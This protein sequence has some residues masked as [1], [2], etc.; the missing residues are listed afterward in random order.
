MITVVSLAIVLAVKM[1]LSGMSID[2]LVSALDQATR[3]QSI[4]PRLDYLLTQFRVIT[5]YIRLIFLPV[6]QRLD[7]DYALSH[8]LFEWQVFASFFVIV[9]LL[10]GAFWLVMVSKSGNPLLRMTAFGII[11]FFLTLSI[12]SSVFPII[13]LIFE[14]RLY[15][16]LFGA[17]TAVSSAVSYATWGRGEPIRR[18]VCIGV[19]LVA[20]TLAVVAYKRNEVWRSEVS[21]W[22]DATEKSPGSARA[23][24]NLAG[25][26]IKEGEHLNALKA[27]VRSIELDPSKADAWNNLGI[28][29]D[30]LGAYKDRFHRTSQMFKN[31]ADVQGS[32]VNSWLG[33][34]HNNLGLAYEIM[35][36][37]PKAAENYRN[38]V[39]YSPALGVAYYNLGIVSVA[40]GDSQTLSGQLQILWMLDP[41]L[42]ERL[43]A[44]SVKR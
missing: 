30:L 13:D 14:H 25:A 20:C 15:L 31:P 6:N 2:K 8:S 28:A 40:L 41:L 1:L 43:Q 17:V 33:E 10:I 27:A 38:A 11:W 26:Y 42:A 4:T 3:L 37:L 12:E 32:T 29:I 19:I 22:M 9:M 35:G 21:L 24:N 44:R 39:G 16:P 7:Y 34:V 5:T 36:N 23:W 18:F